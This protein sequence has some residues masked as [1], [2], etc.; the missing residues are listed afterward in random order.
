MTKARDTIAKRAPPLDEKVRDLLSVRGRAGQPCPRGKIKICSACV[1]GHDSEFC[2]TCEPD[3][4]ATSI[5][6]W[7]K[8]PA[9]TE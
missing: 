1:H 8:I 7:R 6:N 9:K 5:V 4:K 3:E 2:P